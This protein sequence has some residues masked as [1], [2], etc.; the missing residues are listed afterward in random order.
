MKFLPFILM[1]CVS[2]LCMCSLSKNKNINSYNANGKPHGK[3]VYYFN[4]KPQSYGRYKDG[5]PVGKWFIFNPDGSK[6]VKKR[7][8]RNKIREVW[9]YKSGRIEAKGY[10]K[11]ILDD[12]VEINYFWEGKWK[13]FDEKGK[14]Q[15]IS[16]YVK[17]EE[18]KIVKCNG[19][20]TNE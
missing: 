19:T 16:I 5:A 13:F 2:C 9:Y 17:G 10:S 4:E 3:W 15:K 14:L 11:L 18:S 7:Y 8:F 12:P 6:C 1:C 20:Q